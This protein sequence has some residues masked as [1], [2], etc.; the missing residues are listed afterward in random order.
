VTKVGKSRAI[1]SDSRDSDNDNDS[2]NES[3][4]GDNDNDRDND[5]DNDENDNDRGRT[6]RQA[7]QTKANNSRVTNVDN[8]DHKSQVKKKNPY[9]KRDTSATKEK[10]VELDLHG[11]KRAY[12]RFFRCS[13]LSRT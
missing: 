9:N 12:A 6:R 2:D 13:I 3:D 5:N 4:K 8:V 11:K 7:G 10:A 1:R